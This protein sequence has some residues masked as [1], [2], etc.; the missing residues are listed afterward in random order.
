MSDSL[1]VTARAALTT[2]LSELSNRQNLC[3]QSPEFIVK[4]SLYSP[5]IF[6][7]FN[8]IFAQ[9]FG[10]KSVKIQRMTNR[11][12]HHSGIIFAQLFGTKLVKNSTQD[13]QERPPLRHQFCTTFQSKFNQHGQP[14]TSVRHLLP[15]WTQQV[16][17]NQ[18]HQN[19][20][21]RPSFTHPTRSSTTTLPTSQSEYSTCLG[22]CKQNT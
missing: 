10:N 19:L 5:K 2:A 16:R 14:K 21:D 3:S 8:I 9:L 15:H 22:V 11:N 1:T 12:I 20:Q 13:Q 7:H 17:P 6:G 18:R 4:R